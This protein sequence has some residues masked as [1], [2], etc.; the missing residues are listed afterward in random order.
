MI[1]IAVPHK[2]IYIEKLNILGVPLTKFKSYA[3]AEN[4]IIKRIKEK[5]K[6]FCVAINPEKTYRSFSDRNLKEVFDQ[7]DLHICDGVGSAIAARWLTGH[8]VARITGVQLFL[9]LMVRAEKEKLKV[10]LLGGA[11]DVN[12]GAYNYL[13]DKHPELQIVGSKDGYFKDDNDVIEHINKTKP[14]MLFVAM[15]SPKQ[16][17]WISRHMKKLN[18]SYF[19][20]VGGTF[21]V[22]S[23]KV[24][25]APAFYRRTGTEFLYRFA[26]E[27]GKRWRREIIRLKFGLKVIRSKL[28]GSKR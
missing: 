3:H 12:Q 7:A 16:E 15:G 9:N 17:Y 14:D 26:C 18:V 2:S 5:E 4:Y 20:G 23:G 1:K 19:M 6:S 21:D 28:F 13:R 22:V 25:W 8:K 11:P 27:P 24:K 10:Y